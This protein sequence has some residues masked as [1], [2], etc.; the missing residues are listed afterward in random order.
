[1]EAEGAGRR[2]Q[3][4]ATGRGRARG[5]VAAG[6]S[7]PRRWDVVCLPVPEEPEVS[8]IKRLVGL[9]GETLRILVRRR[10]SSNPR[11]D[12]FRLARKPLEHLRAMQMMVYDILPAQG[13]QDLP[14]WRR[15]TV[16]RRCRL[17]RGRDQSGDL[18]PAPGAEGWPSS[19]PAPRARPR[20]VAC[21]ETG[22]PLPR[23]P[24]PDLI[25]DFYSY[26]TNLSA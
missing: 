1:V 5:A 17:G 2:S 23:P 20:P 15:W 3:G 9:A 7:N 22:D 13:P 16:R 10:P 18:H 11:W 21:L 12:E 14:D 8:L 19:L 4:H 6:S 24:R 25:T 26:N